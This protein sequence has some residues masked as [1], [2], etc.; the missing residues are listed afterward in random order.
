[1]L[2]QL[3]C[4]GGDGETFVA[5]RTTKPNLANFITSNRQRRGRLDPEAGT[6]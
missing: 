1:M 2:E 4:A 6:A 3:I 5:A